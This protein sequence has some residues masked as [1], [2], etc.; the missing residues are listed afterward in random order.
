MFGNGDESAQSCRSRAFLDD[1]ATHLR[2]IHLSPDIE[3]EGSLKTSVASIVREYVIERL[4][5][6]T[7]VYVAVDKKVATQEDRDKWKESKPLQN[8]TVYGSPNSTDIFIC[9]DPTAAQGPPES[10]VS[11]ELEFFKKKRGAKTATTLPSIL[12]H[13]LGQCLIASLRHNV[14]C[15]IVGQSLPAP[16]PIPTPRK[17][18][19][20]ARNP[21]Y[22]ADLI[23]RRDDLA[24]LLDQLSNSPVTLI[25]REL[26]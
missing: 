24:P 22:D 19:I 9:D 11:I 1:L 18:P 20:L 14:I 25:V 23:D 13:T 16:K 17:E 26:G 6:K 4:G 7:A 5:P 3:S 10:G 12:H 8:V 2:H 21:K 15:L